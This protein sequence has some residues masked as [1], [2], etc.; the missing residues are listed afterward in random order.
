MQEI[1]ELWVEERR[2]EK[3]SQIAADFV[4]ET[5]DVS[6]SETRSI[7]QEALDSEDV[8][9]RCVVVIIWR[10]FEAECAK[11]GFDSSDHALPQLLDDIQRW[12]E[13]CDELPRDEAVM[14]DLET[15]FRTESEGKWQ[16]LGFSI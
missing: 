13:G 10:W 2:W 1:G 11:R 12:S 9:P 6:V 16:Q 4:S 14:A 7:Y 3:D 15:R 5:F 8:V